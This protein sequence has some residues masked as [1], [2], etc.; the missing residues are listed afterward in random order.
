[1]L[2]LIFSKDRPMQLDA[3]IRSLE[4]HCSDY[5]DLYIRVIY[6]SSAALFEK[7]YGLLRQQ[8]SGHSHIGWVPEGDFKTDLLGLLLRFGNVLFLVDDNIF[9]RCF[10]AAAVQGALAAHSNAIGFSLRLGENTTYC[11]SLDRPQRL[12]VFQAAGENIRLFDWCRAEADF[13]Y[14]L[15]VSSS[16]YR[17]AD[18]IPLLLSFEFHNPNTLEA[19]MFK[20]CLAFEATHPRLLCY[21]Q[22]VAFSNP[23]NK[24]QTV[25]PG[26]RAGADSANT[27]QRL[28]LKF[29]A[30]YRMDTA[31]FT[32]FRPNACHQEI[33]VAFLPKPSRP[34]VSVIIP[35]YRQAQFLP[36]AVES[37]VR[38]TYPHWECLIVNDGSPDQTSTVARHLMSKHRQHRLVLVEKANGG[39]A[40][41]RNAGIRCAQGEYILPLDS[42]DILHPQMIEKSIDLLETDRRVAIAYCDIVHFGVS[43]KL[44]TAADYNFRRLLYQNHLS[45]C[46]LFRREAWEAVGGYNPHMALGYED[47]DFWIG[48][49]ERGFTAKRI[50][51]PLFFYRV[52][53]E[54]MYTHAKANHFQLAAQI[55]LNHPGLYSHSEVDRARNL[56]G[57]SN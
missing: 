34:L 23:I 45:Y 9:T 17:T 2:T 29:T 3:A 26:N 25:C 40:S 52:K 31:P 21:R 42:D 22:S 24:V 39:L 38:Q 57:R 54:S 7:G 6:K 18:L 13:R 51:E 46:S 44:I 1:M 12:P 43:Q 15:E 11:Y 5:N 55:V 53:P 28:A 36:Q 4:A 48:C 16:V 56:L 20:R 27:A 33:E 10:S 32:G 14:P 47:W 8:L 41:A 19:G 30:G 37:V 35:C 49:G 50:P